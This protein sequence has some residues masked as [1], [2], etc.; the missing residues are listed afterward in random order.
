MSSGFSLKNHHDRQRER[1][2]ARFFRTLF[3]VGFLIVIFLAGLHL[4]GIKSQRQNENL[5]IKLQRLKSDYSNIEKEIIDLRTENKTLTLKNKTLNE[6]YLKDVPKGDLGLLS[7][8][9]RE[10]L[11][12][13]M[14]SERLAFIIRQAQPPKNCTQPEKKRFVINTPVYNGPKSSVSFANG[15]ITLTGSGQATIT[16]SG[17]KEAWFDPGKDV[18]IQFTKLGGT[19]DIKKSILPIHHN[20]ILGEREYRFTIAKGPRSFVNVTADSCDYKIN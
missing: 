8:L 1:S 6:R 12:K 2:K 18:S 17:Q 5:K 15:A 7:S 16:N 3:F 9:L 14:S 4:G 20:I 19:A 10:Q 13:G 11:D